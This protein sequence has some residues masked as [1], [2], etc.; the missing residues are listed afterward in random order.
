MRL[1]ASPRLAPE[2]SE[3]IERGYQAREDVVCRALLR[4]IETTPDAVTQDRLGFLA[5]MIAEERLEVQIALPVDSEGRLRR[6]LYHEKLGIFTDDQ[7][8]SVVFTGS[9]NETGGGLVENFEALDVFCSWKDPEGRVPRKINHFEKLWEN[10]TDGLSVVS[11]PAAARAR[12]LEYRPVTRPT[13]EPQSLSESFQSFPAYLWDHQIE[14][15]QAWEA[16]HR[17]GLLSMA[18][19]SGKTR[20]ALVATERC[21]SLNLVVIAVPSK[22]L[23][24]QWDEKLREHTDLPSAILVQDSY[25][26]WQERLFSQL[27]AARRAP[28][29]KPVVAIGTLK[30]LAGQ[31]FESVFEDGGV[32][33][34]VLLIID[35]VHN[36]GAPTYQRVLRESFPWRL[37]LSATPTRHFDEQGT[38]K[39]QEYFGS[40]VYSYTMRQALDEDRLC[41]YRY[42]VYPA[43]LSEEEFEEYTTLTQQILAGRGKGTQEVSQRTDNRLDQDSERVKQLLIRR[44][45]ILKKC[46]A[47]MEALERA[48][49]EHPSKRGLIYCA[50]HEQLERAAE[51]LQQTQHLYLTYTSKTKPAKRH[52]VLDALATGHV[53][54]VVAI[55]CLDE[56]VDVPAVDEA[57]ILASSSN[58][59][60]FIQRRGRILR[61]A[62][63]KAEATLIDVLALPPPSQ[64]TS[65]RWMLQ[66]ELARVKE[67]AELAANREDALLSVKKC[68][69]QYGV[70]LIELMSGEGDG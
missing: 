10:E 50:D 45:R 66:G 12:L 62:A 21:P 18:T 68:A 11:F 13:S 65:A 32:S 24:E 23:V 39:L 44:A 19:G 47:K 6:G 34:R 2:D 40:T 46:E 5:W 69:E 3:A 41:P 35:E 64:G 43:H 67:M 20:I 48:L 63:G 38:A 56:G 54:W 37:G 58:K 51:V 60:Q 26:Q 61:D 59:R 49:A 57:I 33:D 4:E 8:N 22:P 16:N 29:S 17:Q 53:P 1:V 42:Y 14:A 27:R 70:L 30:S 28:D 25:R 36:A 31:R 7:G 9:P 55:D 15:I 52:Q